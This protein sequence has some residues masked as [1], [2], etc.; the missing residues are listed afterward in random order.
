MPKALHR[1]WSTCSVSVFG[2]P[3]SCL[4]AHAGTEAVSNA[5]F[6]E[7]DEGYAAAGLQKDGTMWARLTWMGTGKTVTLV[8]SQGDPPDSM[9]GKIGVR[10][11]AL[12]AK[13]GSTKEA[14]RETVR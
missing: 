5:I 4:R 6:A 9:L 13:D 7:G 11:L 12:S 2:I 1:P 3:S 10:A 14:F 8:T